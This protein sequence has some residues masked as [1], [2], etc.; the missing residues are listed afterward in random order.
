MGSIILMQEIIAST[1][2][3][4]SDNVGDMQVLARQ[5][6]AVRQLLSCC[7]LASYTS[8]V[9]VHTRDQ[10][11]S[12]RLVSPHAVHAAQPFSQ[13]QRCRDQ[14]SRSAALLPEAPGLALKGSSQLCTILFQTHCFGAGCG[15]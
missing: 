2:A 9:V 11:L 7:S 10:T 5:V 12:Q 6:A 8:M 14:D 4:N 13:K 15:A 1:E 3:G